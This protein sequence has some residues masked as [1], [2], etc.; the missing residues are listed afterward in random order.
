MGGIP[1]VSIS[2]LKSAELLLTFYRFLSFLPP[3]LKSNDSVAMASEPPD[4]MTN[5]EPVEVTEECSSK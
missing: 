5:Q 3:S 4:V 2:S 1:S